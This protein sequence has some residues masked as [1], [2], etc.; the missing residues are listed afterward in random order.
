MK[1]MLFLVLACLLST[2]AWAARTHFQVRCEDSMN[3]TVSVITARE[4]GYSI[5]NTRSLRSLTTM[6]GAAPANAYVLGITRTESRMSVGMDGTIL[7][8][9][10][11]QHECVAPQIQV[12]LY[13][14]PIVIY[15]GSEFSPGTCAYKEILA[16]EMRH[17]N[18]YLDHL[19]KVETKVRAALE[20]RFGDRPL[21]APTGQAMALLKREVD[22]GWMPYI[23]SELTQVEVAQAAIDTPR[24]YAR[25]SKICKGEVQS[26]IGPVKRKR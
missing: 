4:N 18:T 5:D 26:I 17:L 13:Y 25:L 12:K 3:K 1:A 23:K 9:P 16:H 11:T 10:L 14:I 6:K 8:D 2:S 24:E 15:I 7:R 20:K 22:T 19:P 21:Y